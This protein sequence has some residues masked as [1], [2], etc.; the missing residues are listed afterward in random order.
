MSAAGC[1]REP[2]LLAVLRSGA[3][4]AACDE[5]LR[6]HAAA[7]PGC[8]DLVEVATALLEDR[9]AGIR[10]AP[11]P[12]SGL[13]WWKMQLRLRQ[14]AVRSARRTLLVVQATA[15]LLSVVMAP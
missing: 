6:D 10:E 5:D 14:D 2:E 9:D 1:P 7:C 13:V 15:L 11:L 3:W 12:G 8:R 4:P